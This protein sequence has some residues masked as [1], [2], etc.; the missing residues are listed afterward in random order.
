MDR[1]R[2]AIASIVLAFSA[3][4][5]ADGFVPW[6]DRPITP[7]KGTA[8]ITLDFLVGLDEGAAGKV[9][10]PAAGLA[11]DRYSGLAVRAGVFNG[12]ELGFAGQF[13]WAEAGGGR[14]LAGYPYSF[15]FTTGD[16][17]LVP[18]YMYGKY[19]IIEVLGVELGFLLSPEQQLGNNRPALRLGLPFKWVFSPGMLAVHV[20]PDVVVGFADMDNP[21]VV[22]REAV[23]VSFYADAGIAFNL[24]PELFLDLTLA[25][26]RNVFPDERGYLPVSF[27]VGWT[28]I[29]SLDVFAG[30]TLANLDPPAGSRVAGRHLSIGLAH[31]W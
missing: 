12:F 17:H 18:L 10:G 26:G 11:W 24:L 28:P 7:P 14:Q 31:R 6:V 8:E 16:S 2:L 21:D 9:L 22:V 4:A 3:T 25:Y 23:Q 15:Q 20:R 5:A 30:F 13:L 1:V 19:E 27:A 29:G